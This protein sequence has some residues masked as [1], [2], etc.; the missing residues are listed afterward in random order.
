MYDNCPPNC[1]QCLNDDREEPLDVVSEDE[2]EVDEGTD[3]I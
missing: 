2:W 3:E 1:A